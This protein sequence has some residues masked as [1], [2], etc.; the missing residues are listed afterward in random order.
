MVKWHLLGGP[1]SPGQCS[2]WWE[3]MGQLRTAP[4]PWAAGGC[5]VPCLG[6]RVPALPRDLLA[7]PPTPWSSGAAAPA[8][9]FTDKCFNWKFP[10]PSWAQKVNPDVS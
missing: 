2:L 7:Q 4:Q 8:C 3:Q 5:S 9:T 10:R 1:C 6:H